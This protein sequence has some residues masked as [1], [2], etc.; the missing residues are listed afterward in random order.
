MPRLTHSVPKYRKHRAS[1]QAVVTLAGKDHYLGPH[2][3]KASRLEYDRVVTE[4]LAAGRPAATVSDN[5][6]TVSDILANYW[7][8]AKGHYQKRGKGTSELDNIKY[9]IR[10][11][12]E[13]YGRTAV[14]DFG[15]LA[16]KALQVRMVADGLSRGVVNS[17]IGK[18]KRIFRWAVSEELAPPSLMHALDTV[19][20]LQKGRTEARET[21]PVEPVDDE[22]VDATLPH[23]PV[24]VAD[25][26]AVQ[27]LTGMRPQ[28]VCNLRPTDIDRTADVWLYRPATHKNEHHGKDRIVCIGSKGQEIL[29]PYLL[30]SPEA[31]CFSPAESEQRR[32]AE[33]RAN[34][35]TKVQPSQVDRSKRTAKRKPGD[36]Y[37][38]NS[39]LYA[40]RRA[41]EKAGVSKWAPNQLRHA[42]GTEI[43]KK[44]GLEAAQVVL[45]H[46]KA[47]VTQVY[48]ER[49]LTLA[50]QVARQVG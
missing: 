29:L 11:L 24:V 27:R 17:R 5:E 48:A 41:A 23:L 40:V 50:V 2:G 39:Y 3:T 37:T 16:L 6:L 21:E 25:M 30:R 28:D 15:P 33:L 49:D 9:A 34:R 7:K 4:W 8:F 31:F 44:F 10:P 18:V 38:S 1:G 32:K 13:L 19:A 42:A 14:Q 43:R 20:G 12:R 45:G 35:K 22:T 36:Q 46:S 26:V 47:D